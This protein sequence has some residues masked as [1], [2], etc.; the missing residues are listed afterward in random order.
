[1]ESYNFVVI[2]SPQILSG[3]KEDAIPSWGKMLPQQMVEHLSL[4]FKYASKKVIAKPFMPQERMAFY[5]A[6]FFS[7]S[8]QI[9][10]EFTAK[11]LIPPDQ[12][13]GLRFNSL[14]EAIAKY[15][16]SLQEFDNFFK[17]N[18]LA[19][20]FHPFFGYLSYDEWFFYHN[21]HIRH[22]FLQ[23][24]LIDEAGNPVALSEYSGV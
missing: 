3:L 16:S 6:K 9:K 8:M 22:H 21:L 24:Q 12:V 4:R 1:M 5:K 7:G 23:F 15:K 20:T 13:S 11:G 17:I 14:E 2:Q 10:K 19:L 18:P